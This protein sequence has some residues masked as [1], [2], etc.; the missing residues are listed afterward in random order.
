MSTAT[1]A[2]LNTSVAVKGM[3]REVQAQ[4]EQNRADAGQQA[5]ELQDRVEKIEASLVRLTDQLNQFKPASAEHVSVVQEVV[6][7]TVDKCL[8]LQSERMDNSFDSVHRA[9][10]SSTNTAGLLQALQISVENLG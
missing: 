8:D 10:Q 7:A 4:L 6:I 5:H 1:T 2:E 9:H 3:R